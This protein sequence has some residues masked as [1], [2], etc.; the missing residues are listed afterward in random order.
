MG[1]TLTSVVGDASVNG[2]V[3]SVGGVSLALPS[4]PPALAGRTVS[5]RLFYVTRDGKPLPLLIV[6]EGIFWRYD[7]LLDAQG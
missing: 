1:Y 3:L 4:V 6:G 7:A 5:V 2:D